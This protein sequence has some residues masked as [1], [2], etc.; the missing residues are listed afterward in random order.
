[1]DEWRNDVLAEFVC[2]KDDTI[3]FLAG[4]LLNFVKKQNGDPLH[5]GTLRTYFNLAHQVLH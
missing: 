1:M 3:E 4:Y 2:T 5:L